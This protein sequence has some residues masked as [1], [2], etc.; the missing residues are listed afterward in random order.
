MA[1]RHLKCSC[2]SCDT[3]WR[4]ARRNIDRA[5]ARGGPFCPV[6]R[7]PATVGDAEPLSSEQR[8]QIAK[9]CERVAAEAVE[10]LNAA[11]LKRRAE[12]MRHRAR[13]AKGGS[14]G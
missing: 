10:P 8:E 13:Y 12:I 9:L 5:A 14:D 3:I 11:E 6:C 1:S 7:E 4:M 2:Q